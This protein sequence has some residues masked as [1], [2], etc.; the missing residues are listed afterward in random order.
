L[1]L[2]TLTD[3]ELM[4]FHL[5]HLEYKMMLCAE[6]TASTGKVIRTSKMMDAAGL[7]T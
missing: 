7:G 3:D 6:L 4:T 5:Y 1:L 2:K